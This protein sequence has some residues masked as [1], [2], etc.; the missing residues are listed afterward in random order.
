MSASILIP[1][2]G[3]L[4]NVD[5]E[6]SYPGGRYPLG[7]E[8]EVKNATYGRQ[9]WRYIY[10][11]SGSEIGANLGVM[12]ENGTTEY[13]VSLSTTGIA[14]QRILGVTQHAIATASY[15]WVLFDGMGLAKSDGSTTADTPQKPAAN[16]KFTDGTVGS[17][18]IC[19]HAMETE[20]PAGDGGL[21]Q[22][23]VRL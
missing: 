15:G 5:S 8:T 1:L 2:V 7:A 12:Q 11:N 17:D 4:T 23:L 10:N 19:G 16:G 20:S 3:A 14:V 13:E 21:F 9:K 6:S 22:M 18:S